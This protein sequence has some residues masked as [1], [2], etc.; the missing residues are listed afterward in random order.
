MQGNYKVLPTASIVFKIF[1]WI[2]LVLGMVSAGRNHLSW[3]MNG[4][5]K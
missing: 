4:R 1:A 3:D 5:I 2:G